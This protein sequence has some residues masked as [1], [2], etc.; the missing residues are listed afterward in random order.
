MHIRNRS[1]LN[2]LAYRKTISLL[3]LSKLGGMLRLI[4]L[5]ITELGVLHFCFRFL[6]TIEEQEMFKNFT[7]DKNSLQTADIF[8]S[9]VN[10]KQL[11]NLNVNSLTAVVGGSTTPHKIGFD[12]HREGVSCQL[13][14]IAT[15]KCS[16]NSLQTTVELNQCV[17]ACLC[18]R[19]F[20]R[21]A[22]G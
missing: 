9:K 4:R 21:N 6:P 2:L 16:F 12:F 22:C 7:G 14:W 13:C 17:C 11:L 1:K 3:R 18:A 15:R 8:I 10:A 5:C 20:G 19:A